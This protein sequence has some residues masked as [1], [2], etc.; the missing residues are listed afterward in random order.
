MKRIAKTFLI[1]VLLLAVPQCCYSQ[2]FQRLH[3]CDTSYD[4]G[5]NLFLQ[6]DN[7][8]FAVGWDVRSGDQF[9]IY[10]MIISSD[11]TTIL[12][13]HFL[14]LDSTAIGE[15][16]PGKIRRTATGC[17]YVPG[18]LQ[19]PRDTFLSSQ[20][21][22][23]KYN[24]T[25][26][27]AFLKAYTDTSRFFDNLIACAVMPDNGVL[28][29]G[30]RAPYGL[31]DQG[32]LIRSDSSGDTLWSHVYPEI[33]GEVAWFTDLIPI[34]NNRIAASALSRYTYWYG[35][36][37]F[38]QAY[39]HYTPIYMIIDSAGN[40]LKDT[41]YGHRYSGGGNISPDRF[42]GYMQWGWI[43]TIVDET[44][45]YAIPN[46]PFYV[47]HLDTNFHMDWKIELQPSNFNGQRQIWQIK[48]LQ[49][50]NFIA[51]GDQ[52]TYYRPHTVGWAMK[53]TPAGDILWQHS[54]F[55]DSNHFAYIRDMIEKPD[56][57]LVFIGQTFNDTLP[58]WH[59]GADLWLVGVDS[60]GCEIAGCGPGLWPA[61]TGTLVKPGVGLK[62]YPNPTTGELTVRVPEAGTFTL[63][64]LQGQHVQQ[65]QLPKGETL[66][67]LPEQLAT[68]M[69]M[70]R[71][72]N[73]QGGSEVVKVMKE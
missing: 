18:T 22:L 27:T 69:Y 2:Y 21:C 54:Y 16:D 63:Y 10:N 66:L 30:G 56:G 33:E 6:A 60:N 29:G 71:Y 24:A 8:Y 55:S 12:S 61:G 7:N 36:G 25:G 70:G 31:P 46:F 13:S 32:L 3:D 51:M 37:A 26:D 28:L 43:D 23:I 57:N 52:D 20:S 68:G 5:W 58:V 17:Y 59:N 14:H 11:G 35:T 9:G 39:Y 67:R 64:N 53:V 1:A 62:V 65:Y 48:Q 38:L 45:P 44:D 34:N 40:V 72:T 47:A 15:G 73:E 49:D 42:G 19:R 4:W 50:G 41:V